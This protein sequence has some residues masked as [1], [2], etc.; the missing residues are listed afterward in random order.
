MTTDSFMGDPRAAASLLGD[1]NAHRSTASHLFSATQLSRTITNPLNGFAWQL[2]GAGIVVWRFWS[3]LLR[4]RQDVDV[5]V[6]KVDRLGDWLLAGPS[7]ERIVADGRARGGTVVLWT[8]DESV[9]IRRWRESSSKVES[10]ALEPVGAIAKMR[11]AWKVMRL[12]ATYRVR[13]FICLRHAPEQI[14]DFVLRYVDA[15]EIRALSW[16]IK[17][18]PPGKVPHEILRHRAI[19]AATDLAPFDPRELLPVLPGRTSAR[20]GVVVVAPFSSGIIKDWTDESWVK[21][22]QGMASRGFRCELWVGPAQLSRAGALADKIT[23]AGSFPRASV[24][25]GTL[26]ELAAAI[27]GCAIV[28]SVDTFA[29]HLAVAM[30]VP[31]VSLI[32]GGQYGDFGPWQR[33]ARQRWLTNPLPCFGCDWQCTRSR[34][35]CMEDISAESMLGEADEALQCDVARN[36]DTTASNQS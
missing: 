17:G 28:L 36:A 5:V 4:Q 3:T 12:L 33:S 6:Y 14:R 7:I 29:A 13:S 22:A 30:D 18:Q 34:V 32:G 23:A 10:F 1:R 31:L 15:K 25:T 20:G 35:E 2:C 21:V 8:A 27:E 19:L 9:L 16:V 11:R 24:R 26:G